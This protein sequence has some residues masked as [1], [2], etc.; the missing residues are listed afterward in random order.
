MGDLSKLIEVEDNVNTLANIFSISDPVFEY[1]ASTG[2]RSSTTISCDA[3]FEISMK[4]VESNVS[5]SSS[6]FVCGSLVTPRYFPCNCIPC[7]TNSF[8]F[9]KIISGMTDHR[10]AFDMCMSPA[11]CASAMSLGSVL[12]SRYSVRTFFPLLNRRSSAPFFRFST[13]VNISCMSKTGMP[14]RA[15]L[16]LYSS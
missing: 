4:N 13:F 2:M 15:S 12:V 5:R 7:S 3:S 6:V 16:F 8:R 10:P 14:R 11:I 1:F 9:R